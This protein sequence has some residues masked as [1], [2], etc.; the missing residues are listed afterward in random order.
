VGAAIKAAGGEATLDKLK[1]VTLKGKGTVQEGEQEGTFTIETTVQGGDRFRLELIMDGTEKALLV[2]SGDKGWR[3][4]GDRVRD[5]PAEII[6]LLKAELRALRMAQMLTPL[7]EKE[8][9]LSPLGEVQIKDRSALGIKVAEKD[10]PDVDL[11]FD[12]ETH[13]PLWCELKVKER[14]DNEVTTEW[15]FSEFTELAG[16]KHPKKVSLNRDG[17]KIMEMEIS[18]LKPVEKVDEKIFAKP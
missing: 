10:H 3:K 1:I 9:K 7:K 4:G 11:Y 8:R 18:E 13:L 5:L 15:I 14:A 12:K 2:L 6:T 17:T 16:I